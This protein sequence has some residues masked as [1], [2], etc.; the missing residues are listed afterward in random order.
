MRR[1]MLFSAPSAL[2]FLA[3]SAHAFLFHETTAS[4][5]YHS[6][7]F[8]VKNDE[9]ADLAILHKRIHELKVSILAD[10]LNL[11]PNTFV[12]P[13]ELIRG[14]LYGLLNPPLPDAGFHLILR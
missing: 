11:P 3:T 2:L 6:T 5:V 12:S 10:E 1:G 8:S 14:I 7:L 9:E 13:S 4:S